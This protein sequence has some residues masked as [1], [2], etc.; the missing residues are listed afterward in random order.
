VKGIC[1]SMPDW[2]SMVNM[3]YIAASDNAKWIIGPFLLSK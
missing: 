2:W 1:A 3:D